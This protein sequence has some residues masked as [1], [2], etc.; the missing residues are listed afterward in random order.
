VGGA[1]IQQ[2]DVR[3]LS[4][5]HRDL[6]RMTEK[7]EFREDLFYRLNVFPVRLPALRQRLEDIPVLARHFLSAF[8]RANP[9]RHWTLSAEAVELLQ[10][11]RWPGNVRELRNV[12]ERATLLCEGSRIQVAH[13]PDHIIRFALA[14][15]VDGYG[16]AKGA[17]QLMIEE[18]LLRARGNKSAAAEQIG[19]HRSRLYRRMRVLGIRRGFGEPRRP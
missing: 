2:V 5:T 12:L 14:E 10:R 19:W 16:G 11:Y 13:L 6:N 15:P 17:E 18:A 9:G 3:L 8:A 1:R 4:A 7:G